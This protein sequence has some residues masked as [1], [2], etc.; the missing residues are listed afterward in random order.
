MRKT[1]I[2]ILVLVVLTF[3]YAAWPFYTIYRFIEA[4]DTNDAAAVARLVD[5]TA[6]RYS[7]AQQIV[8]AYFRR[9]G[10]RINPLARAIASDTAVSLADPL[11]AKLITPAAF[12][13]LMKSGASPA[14]AP[15]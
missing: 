2:T 12:I 15:D 6:L 9:T 7:L 8:E 14:A 1:L 10:T 11:V 13:D 4:I 3:S 5:F